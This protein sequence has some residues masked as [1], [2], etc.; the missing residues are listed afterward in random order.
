[1]M[2]GFGISLSVALMLARPGSPLQNKTDK[3]RDGF[4]GQVYAVSE[5]TL[6][7]TQQKAKAPSGAERHT[8]SYYDKDGA[9]TLRL[10]YV[11][12]QMVRRRSFRHTS[13]GEIMETIEDGGVDSGADF[14][15]PNPPPNRVIR[16]SLKFDSDGNLAEESL[17]GD[18]GK[19]L[20]RTTFK[21]DARGRAVK[22]T[23]NSRG[24]SADDGSRT[25]KY[26]A[27]NDPA[28]STYEFFPGRPVTE[29]FA[30]ELDS[31]GN[32]TARREQDSGDIV[33]RTIAY[34]GPEAGAS[35]LPPTAGI[36]GESPNDRLQPT[37]LSALPKV[38][39]RTGA[40]LQALA[41]RKVEPAYPMGARSAHITGSVVVEVR[42]DHSGAV[43]DAK[44]I[45][46]PVELQGAA[47]EAAR[48]WLFQPTSIGGLR[49]DVIGTITFHFMM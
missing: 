7:A 13:P 9:L 47:V 28:S 12:G 36:P 42:I 31:K 35:A 27:G 14:V 11:E 2:K 8:T 33:R 20:Q 29:H 5:A 44:A 4:S 23:V 19:E 21:R 22:V 46:G 25:Y 16:H 10:D 40:T 34:Y 45:N 43:V 30:Y 6:S 37:P 41:I 15:G 17:F 48:Q 49:L 26:S 24:G 1:M 3:Q 18:D 39:R 38:L 32:W